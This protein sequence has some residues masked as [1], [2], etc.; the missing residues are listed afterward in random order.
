MTAVV[1]TSSSTRS[2]D[3]TAT[4]VCTW[5]V[6]P[7]SRRSM[8]RASAASI[9]LPRMSPSTSTIVSAASDGVPST[10]RALAAAR[11]ATRS[12]GRSPGRGVSSTSAGPTVNGDPEL[13]RAAPAGAASPRPG[14][15][16][17]SRRDPRRALGRRAT[18]GSVRVIASPPARTTVASVTGNHGSRSGQRA[19][20][21]SRATA[22]AAIGAYGRARA[23]GQRRLDGG[24]GRPRGP[25]ACPPARGGRTP[26][27]S[28]RSSATVAGTRRRRARGRSRRPG[29]RTRRSSAARQRRRRRSGGAPEE[30]VELGDVHPLEEVRVEA[31]YGRP[32]GAG[33]RTRRGRPAPRRPRRSASSTV[34]NVV[35]AR[36][37]L[38]RAR[39]PTGRRGSRS[40]RRHRPSP[41]GAAPAGAA[42]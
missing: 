33:P 42:R 3:R 25:P 10:A 1:T 28:D 4:P 8:R 40:G 34:P 6:R 38:V 17:P 24:T 27:S 32:S 21:G 7:D 23:S 31:A 18:S 2:P 26:C 36:K 16:R 19:Q 9:G 37:W 30:A 39:R 15:A 14:R 13:R 12:R 29:R 20:R 22:A 35:R 5:W 11:R 41:A